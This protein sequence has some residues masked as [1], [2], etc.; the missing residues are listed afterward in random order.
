MSESLGDQRL[1]ERTNLYQLSAMSGLAYE[2]GKQYGMLVP[3]G[4]GSERERVAIR[5]GVG[6]DEAK[7]EK[8]LEEIAE[9]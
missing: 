8:R 7:M 9:R 5:H 2:S 3:G 1:L 4:E 6:E